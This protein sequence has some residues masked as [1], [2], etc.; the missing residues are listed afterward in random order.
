MLLAFGAAAERFKLRLISAKG[1]AIVPNADV[2]Q[3]VS[4]RV[5]QGG[6]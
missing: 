3:I 6:Q 5:W 2:V 1:S 4:E